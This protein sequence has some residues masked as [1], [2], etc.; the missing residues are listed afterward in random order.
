[1]VNI[2]DKLNQPFDAFVMAEF[3]GSPHSNEQSTE[4][5]EI[6]PFNPEEE[7]YRDLVQGLRKI[8]KEDLARLAKVLLNILKSS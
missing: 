2:S 1:M 7:I 6:D 5:A 8:P 3:S 4:D